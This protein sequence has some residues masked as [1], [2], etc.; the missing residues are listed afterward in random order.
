MELLHTD[1]LEEAREKLKSETEDFKLRER[2]VTCEASLGCICAED[3]IAG[4]NVPPFRRSTVDGYAVIAGDSY[5]AGD[6]NPIFFRVAG[7]VNIEERVSI[8]VNSGEAVQMQTGSMIPDRATAVLMVEY[9]E[10]YAADKIVAYKAVSEGE[11]II[12][13]GEDIKKGTCLIRKGRKINSRDIGMMAALGISKVNV[14]VPMILTIISTGDELVDIWESLSASKIRDINSYALAA[15]A[16]ENGWVIRRQIRI[17]DNKEKIFEAVSEAVGES[18]IILLSG[19]SSKGNKDYTKTVL[20]K[21]TRNVFTHGIS[22]KPGKPTILSVEQ[23][24]KVIIVGLPG[25]P[26]AALLMFRLLIV[27]W[28]MSKAGIS[29]PKPYFA[30]MQENVSS[31]Q[32]RATC[33]PVKLVCGEADYNAVPVYAKSG[34]IS[35]LSKTDGYVMIPRNKEGLKKGERVRVEVWA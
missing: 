12:Q 31:N 6:S 11:N 2:R 35:P 28:Y 8:G 1:T 26:M 34:S 25:H 22:I 23:E 14:Y 27:D 5:G 10:S 29:R 18:D 32:G 7:Q 13:I 17:A 33:L 24:H 30:V 9:T 21:I 16:V 3:I 19:G 4:E 15:E 20:E